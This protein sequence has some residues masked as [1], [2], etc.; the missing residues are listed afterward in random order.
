[1]TDATG[2]CGGLGGHNAERSKSAVLVVQRRPEGGHDARRPRP[3][4]YCGVLRRRRS[5]AQAGQKRPGWWT[6][7]VCT[8]ACGYGVVAPAAAITR[9]AKLTPPFMAGVPANHYSTGRT[10][11]Q[12]YGLA[13]RPAHA[14]NARLGRAADGA[15]DTRGPAPT[16]S[17]SITARLP[18]SPSV[19]ALGLSSPGLGHRRDGH[20][21]HA[22]S[23][24]TSD[25]PGRTRCLTPVPQ[26]LSRDLQL[27]GLA[28]DRAL[29]LGDP[30][31][32]LALHRP[33]LSILET[34]RSGLDHLVA[35]PP[36]QPL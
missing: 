17:S 35:P 9:G 2:G 31:P 5:P 15:R 7:Q 19:G 16:S 26:E 6:M 13:A 24:K 8:H 12:P 3:A 34:V 1:M 4:L 14:H 28:P 30:P 21:R 25:R 29:E 32:L 23:H 27:I 10:F 33:L 22:T 20:A 11:T 18:R 36:E